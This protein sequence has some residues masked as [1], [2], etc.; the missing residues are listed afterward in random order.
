MGSMM[1]SVPISFTIY[2]AAF[3][4]ANAILAAS[5]HGSVTDPTKWWHWL[6]FAIL[7]WLYEVFGQNIIKNAGS[8]E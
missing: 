3:V 8:S 2:K 6:L 4:L 5:K 1:W 7:Y